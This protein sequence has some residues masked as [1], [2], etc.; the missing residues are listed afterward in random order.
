MSDNERLDLVKRMRHNK[1]V[2]K[3]AV[4]VKKAKAAAKKS[5]P[6]AK[7]MNKL[8]AGLSDEQKLALLQE[9]EG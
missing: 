1:Y 4:K 3:P 6:R 5:R 7:K 8:L 9:L 2:L